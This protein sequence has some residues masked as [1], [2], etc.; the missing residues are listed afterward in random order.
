LEGAKQKWRM[1][2]AG[3]PDLHATV[4][5]MF[6]EGDR[7]AVRWT[8]EGTHRGELL[9]IPPTG[10]PARISGITIY[11]LAEGRIAEQF[12]RWDNFKSLQKQ[13]A[14]N[15]ST[16][17]DFSSSALYCDTDPGYIWQKVDT[18]THTEVVTG[19]GGTC[20]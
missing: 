4:E 7:V 10:R 14:G 16:W 15:G 11:R 17:F 18:E 13:V 3:V 2:M 5:D 9:G 6:A 8:A 19:S 20:P 12:E 1:Y